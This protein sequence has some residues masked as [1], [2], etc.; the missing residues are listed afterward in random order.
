M[1]A[2]TTHA[3][4]LSRG[5]VL[6]DITETPTTIYFG[7]RGDEV[8]PEDHRRFV[9]WMWPIFEAYRD[10]PRPFE[11]AG[12]HADWTGRIELADGAWRSLCKPIGP[13]Q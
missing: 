1:N 5:T 2:T 4:Q 9:E 11:L 13:L 7:L 3:L 8:P 10:D 12:A 6:V